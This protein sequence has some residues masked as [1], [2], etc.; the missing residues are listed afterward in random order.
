MIYN[1]EYLKAANEFRKENWVGFETIQVEFASEKI[2]VANEFIEACG[3]NITERMDEIKAKI[4]EHFNNIDFSLFIQMPKG[5]QYLLIAAFLWLPIV[6]ACNFDDG[7]V[8]IGTSK[9]NTELTFLSSL[10]STEINTQV[11]KYIKIRWDGFYIED[12]LKWLDEDIAKMMITIIMNNN[13]LSNT[14]RAELIENVVA[15]SDRRE[16]TGSGGDFNKQYVYYSNLYVD[17]KNQWI[18]KFLA[19]Y[20]K[21]NSETKSE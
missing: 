20:W 14:Q 19:F 17:L 16:I 15:S 9:Y 11:T 12:Q 2:K 13:K 21:D 7:I 4:G 3:D 1:S 10:D 5:L 8:P 18:E 6:P